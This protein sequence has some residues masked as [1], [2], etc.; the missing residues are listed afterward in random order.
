[1][2]VVYILKSIVYDKSYVGMTND[3]ERRIGEHNSGR[4]VYTKRFLPWKIIYT[5]V[6]NTSK[7]LG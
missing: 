2:Y 3:I 5:E 4:H 1:M 6:Y 7:K